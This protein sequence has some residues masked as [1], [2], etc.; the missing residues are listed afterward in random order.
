MV[1]NR[2]TKKKMAVYFGFRGLCDDLGQHLMQIIKIYTDN[3]QGIIDD[4]SL[5]FLKIMHIQ[6]VDSHRGHYTSEVHYFLIIKW[7]GVS[8]SAYTIVTTPQ[9]NVQEMYSKTFVRFFLK[10]VCVGE[11]AR[12]K[13]CI[14]LHT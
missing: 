6:S 10:M 9:D 4:G 12:E 7:T 2:L 3:P 13:E 5:Y 11:R 14:A 8:Y 1:L